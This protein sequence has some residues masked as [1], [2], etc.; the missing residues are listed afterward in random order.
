M[1][2]CCIIGKDL[3]RNVANIMLYILSLMK[4]LLTCNKVG[5]L[6]SLF[7]YSCALST[8]ICVYTCEWVSMC[9]CARMRAWVYIC[10]HVY[11]ILSDHQS[12]IL[13]LKVIGLFV[14]RRFEY[15]FFNFYNTTVN[16]SRGVLTVIFYF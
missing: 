4:M 6:F 13:L 8:K 11:S 3:W 9:M 10:M 16:W 2:S 5:G 14:F 7:W 15:F 1:F 12:F